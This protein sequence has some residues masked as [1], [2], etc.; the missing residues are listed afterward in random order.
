MKN[1][2]IKHLLITLIMLIFFLSLISDTKGSQNIPYLDIVSTLHDHYGIVLSN[3]QLYWNGSKTRILAY[4]LDSIDYINSGKTR[5]LIE[6][7][8]H[9]CGVNVYFDKGVKYASLSV[10]VFKYNSKQRFYR[11]KSLFSKEL[12]K[13]LLCLSTD[14]GENKKRVESFLQSH[15]AIYLDTHNHLSL[16]G[17][18]VKSYKSFTPRERMI[19]LHTLIDLSPLIK[20]RPSWTLYL[21]RRK[22]DFQTSHLS[23]STTAQSHILSRHK[24][25]IEFTDEAFIGPESH[26]KTIFIHEIMHFFVEN[27]WQQNLLNQWAN[28][29]SWYRDRSDMDQWSTK[30]EKAFVSPYAHENNPTEDLVESIANYVVYPSYLKSIAPN[31]YRFIKD[32]FMKRIQYLNK[33]PSFLTFIIDGSEKL[34]AFP[35]RA[36]ELK[37]IS[38][39]SYLGEIVLG[40]YLQPEA[41]RERCEAAY[42]ILK[43]YNKNKTPLYVRFLSNK[44]GSCY[45]I[46]K[47][48][49]PQHK[50]PTDSK[51]WAL[52]SIQIYNNLGE[53]RFQSGSDFYFK[54]FSKSKGGKPSLN[55]T[56]SSSSQEA[57]NQKKKINE[58]KEEKTQYAFHYNDRLYPLQLIL[59]SINLQFTP[60]GDSDSRLKLEFQVKDQDLTESDLKKVYFYFADP[61]ETRY[62]FVLTPILIDEEGPLKTYRVHIFLPRGIRG[63]VWSLR[64]VLLQTKKDL[65]LPYKFTHKLLF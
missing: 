3:E 7:K 62:R 44:N 65:I 64:E 24:G 40:L 56:S 19:L 45:L 38:S 11:R 49:L 20:S 12:E 16:T 36:K 10:D 33:I 61:K 43:M 39:S 60:F 59:N 6:D 31:K 25:Y 8:R 30:E 46:S 32:Q 54:L 27:I 51:E 42:V 34:N 4:A 22:K 57:Q 14:F 35:E 37:V 9:K 1:K 23:H 58:K 47:F 13:A 28:L 50:S 53:A 18:Q 48:T 52:D 15:F 21:L 41:G 29:G 26:S 5:L 17:E 55:S 63:G 2:K